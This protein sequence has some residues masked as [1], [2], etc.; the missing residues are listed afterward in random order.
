MTIASYFP[1][2]DWLLCATVTHKV[3]QTSNLNPCLFSTGLHTVFTLCAKLNSISS[4]NHWRTWN[5]SCSEGS[6]VFLQRKGNNIFKVKTQAHN[7]N[8]FVVA[9]GQLFKYPHQMEKMMQFE[10]N[11]IFF[12]FICG[13]GD[14]D[15][16]ENTSDVSYGK[17]CFRQRRAWVFFLLSCLYLGMKNFLRVDEKNVQGSLQ[18]GSL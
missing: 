12:H 18:A 7:L 1:N 9:K 13:L 10:L 5:S 4:Y 15:L 3:F 14:M 6:F 11:F 8:Y 2:W 16:K 17:Q